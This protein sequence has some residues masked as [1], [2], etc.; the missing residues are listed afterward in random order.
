MVRKRIAVSLGLLACLGVVIGAPGVMAGQMAGMVQIAI[1][2]ANGSLLPYASLTYGGTSDKAIR[3]GPGTWAVKPDGS[4][5]VLNVESRNVGEAVVVLDLPAGPPAWV[6]LTLEGDAAEAVFVTEH[7]WPFAFSSAAATATVESVDQ[8]VPVFAIAPELGTESGIWLDPSVQRGPAEPRAGID[9]DECDGAIYHNGTYDAVN[10][11]WA[12][13]REDFSEDRWIIDDVSLPYDVIVTDLHWW[14][15]EPVG[16][17]WSG[18]LA[19]YIILNDVGG[20]PGST[21][22]QELDVS[23]T[24]YDTGDTMFGDPVWLYSIE[25]LSIDLP[26]GNYWFGMRPVQNL[27]FGT[28]AYD[29]G[30]WTTS[31]DNGTSEIYVNYGINA[32]NWD[33]GYDSFGDYYNVA[34]CVTGFMGEPPFGACCDDMTFTCEDCVIMPDCPEGYRFVVETLCEDMDPACGEITGACCDLL[35]G[36]CSEVWPSECTGPDQMYLGDNTV[37]TPN[38]CP[39]VVPCPPGASDEG[40]PCGDDTNGGCNSTPAVFGAV[41]CGETLCGSA[42]AEGGSRDTD[43]YLLTVGDFTRFTWTLESEFP[44]AAFIIEDPAGD[45]STAAVAAAAYSDCAPESA[46]YDVRPGTYYFWVGAGNAVEGIFDGYPCS[47]LETDYV[48]TLGCEPIDPFYCF[49]FWTNCPYPDDWITNVTFNTINNTTGDECAAD[50]PSYG[51]Y[52][53][54]ST[55]INRGSTHTLSVTFSSGTWTQCV[56]AWIDWDQDWL[57]EEDERYD[58]GCGAS[59]TLTAGITVPV[60]AVLGATRLRVI[61]E[62][63]DYPVDSCATGSYGETEDYTVV[64]GEAPPF[65]ACCFPDYSCVVMDEVT[66]VGMGGVYRGDGTDCDPNICVGACCFADGSCDDSADGPAC[67]TAGGSSYLGDG[68]DCGPPNPCPQPG[69]NCGNPV[70]LTVNTTTTPIVNTNYTCGRDN[71][72]EDTCLGSYDDGED[73]L[74]ELNVTETMGIVITVDPKGT[75]YTGFALDDSCPPDG[76]CLAVA[77]AGY[78][79]TPYSSSCI[80]VTP[81]TYYVMVD[82]W[83]SPDCIPDFDLTIEECIVCS[84]DCPGGAHIEADACGEETNGGCNYDPPDFEDINLG[85]TVC[86]ICWADGGTR[87]LDWYRV[88]TTESMILTLDVEAEFGL[89]GVVAGFLEMVVPGSDDCADSTG[90]IA[91]Y[92]TAGE[93]TPFQ[94]VTDCVPAGSY[95]PVVMAGDFYDV[96]CD[97]N[98]DYV[99][100]ITGVPCVPPTGAC[101]RPSGDCIPDLTVGE[102]VAAG[103]VWQGEGTVCDPNPCPQPVAETCDDAA[104]LSGT[105]PITILFDN[106]EATAD[107]PEGTCDKYYPTTTGLMQND[108][109]FEWTAPMN[110][111]AT[112]TVVPTGYDSLV[113]VRDNCVDLNEIACD[114]TG[115]T[116]VTDSVVWS[117]VNGV[118]YYIQV[119]DT[120]SYEGG[121]MTSL[122]IDCSAGTGACC[123]DFTGDCF[124]GTL[125]DCSAAGGD[126]LGDGTDC[127]PP[128]PCPQ[129]N[130][131]D[132][133]VAPYPVTLGLGDLPYV[134]AS[135]TNCGR[136]NWHDDPSTS[137]CLYYY[138]SGEDM[139]YEITVTDAMD[140]DITLDPQGTTYGGVAIGDAC[141]PTDSCLASVYSSSSSPKTTPCVHLEPGI[142]Y[143]QV[144]TWSSPDCIPDFDLTIAEC[145]MPTGRC[146]YDIPPICVDGI[147]EYECTNTY[148]GN[149]DEGLNCIDNPCPVPAYCDACFTNDT[150]DWITNVTFNTIDNTTGNEGDPCSYGDYT[151]QSTDIAQGLTYTLSVTF[152]S[153]TYTECVRAWIDWNQDLDWD[154]AG[155]QYDLGS[156]ASTTVTVDITV[157]GTATLGST[158]M[159]V[160]ERYSTC[161]GPCD[162]LSYGEIED[163]TVNVITPPAPPD[164]KGEW[165]DDDADGYPN[166]CDNCPNDPNTPYLGTCVEGTTG[167]CV[168]H[169]DCDT[170]PGAGDGLCSNNQ[171]D[172][173]GDFVGDVCDNCVDDWNEGQED[174]DGDGVGNVCDNC[175]DDPNPTQDNNDADD[176]GD[177]CDNCP[178]DTNPGQEDYDSDGVGDA[179]DNC[180]TTPNPSQID[181]DSDGYG[182]ACDG[183]PN[184]PNKIEPGICGCGVPDEGDSDDD[185]VLDCV[186]QCPGVDDALF[187]PGCVGAI[188]TTSQWGLLVMALLLLVVGKVYFG[189]RTAR[190]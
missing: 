75:T 172:A 38:P 170:S 10:A 131:G 32:P 67:T 44:G 92:G 169:E 13:R 61:E 53:V 79:S 47:G 104:V 97:S 122:T 88:T 150:D 91:P 41:A 98:N 121:G 153:G 168:V 134:D 151:A 82:T 155:E 119:G 27:P 113:A 4:K 76:S 145:V 176:L 73:I 188:P 62:Y 40:E 19:D 50:P 118:T 59:A 2:D 95:I 57:L 70:G 31:P 129:P 7:N 133:C 55:D 74:Y 85:D 159:R 34:F 125:G 56:S 23:A 128:N 158:R 30:W 102:C 177:A 179:C 178:F 15:N 184:D 157:P 189:R 9:R 33:P 156:G 21:F 117:A 100:T 29:K 165:D 139:I 28:G 68:T 175:P 26:A 182:D 16:F 71:N 86:G 58:L 1:M 137:H 8:E 171:E 110:C 69:D 108:V 149:W 181:T 114:D 101:C 45:C 64:I 87:D 18:Q 89:V 84:V 180:L 183:C 115:D 107:G 66:C 127:G 106:N 167:T 99:F 35:T 140:V 186:D 161:P 96:P 185:G 51:D 52:T 136:G 17:N 141:P 54:L 143:I 14:G 123:D 12:E 132:H 142:Y 6:V 146:C 46:V 49:S 154:D 24:R 135:Q 126:Y 39:C 187:A 63:Y 111:T 112:A 163:Y 22:T 105:L 144:D 164:G 25:G 72:Y 124:V 80:E 152:S 130:P 20:V 11:L 190:A 162:S 160:I 42:W 65:G 138:D 36:D 37:C 147:T 43:W 148:G 109:W 81:G 93:C 83:P 116:S 120:G 48:A 78:S 103:G 166:V 5:L 77:T 90:Y 3:T 174:D 173:D 94:V 60:D